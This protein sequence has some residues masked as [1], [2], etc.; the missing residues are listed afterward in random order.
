MAASTR[1]VRL[2]RRA[3]INPHH[4]LGVYSYG[5]SVAKCWGVHL[6]ADPSQA[7]LWKIDKSID[8]LLKFSCDVGD[9]TRAF[10]T[11]SPGGF[12]AHIGCRCSCVCVHVDPADDDLYWTQSAGDQPGS[13]VLRKA[14]GI[15]ADFALAGLCFP[16]ALSPQDCQPSIAPTEIWKALRIYS[17]RFLGAKAI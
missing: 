16:Q 2:V 6:T 14:K 9:G 17:N 1:S 10:L 4:Y 12:A 11:H 15:H 8:G 3:G 13:T 5:Q 7:T